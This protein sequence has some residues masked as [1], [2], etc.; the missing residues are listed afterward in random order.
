MCNRPLET[1]MSNVSSDAAAL[2]FD[3]QGVLGSWYPVRDYELVLEASYQIQVAPWW[4]VQP[5]VQ[6]VVHPG[7][8]VIDPG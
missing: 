6:Y 7:G 8:K 4:V 3:T 5:D 1:K 2:D